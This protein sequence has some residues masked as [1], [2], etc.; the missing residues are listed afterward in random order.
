MK[1]VKESRM[2]HNFRVGT[3]ALPPL[4]EALPGFLQL[5]EEDLARFDVYGWFIPCFFDDIIE[6]R[7]LK[8]KVFKSKGPC[9]LGAANI[10]EK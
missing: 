5:V 1:D 2:Q 7:K 10:G 8:P 6:T 4:V 3:Y 9:P